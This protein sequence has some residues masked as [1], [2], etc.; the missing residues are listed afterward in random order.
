MHRPGREHL[1]ADYLSRLE[2]GEPPEGI[3]DDLPNADLFQ[4]QATKSDDWYEQMINY[5]TEGIFPEGMTKDHTR[6]LVL[7][8]A[9]YSV[10]GGYLYKR[11]VDQIIK[12]CVP[13]SQQAT[14]LTEAHTRSS[15]GHF[16]R[17]ITSRKIFQSGLW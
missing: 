5:L 17:D 4:I 11:G 3:P 16:S 2:S 8:S 10:I 1:I 6:K 13:D 7:R 12:R 14:V 9:T 15:G